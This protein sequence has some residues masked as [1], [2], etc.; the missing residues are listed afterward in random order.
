QSCVA[1]HGADGRGIK[2]A[3]SEVALAPSLVDSPRVHSEPGNLVMIL[4]HGL[5]GPLD[6]KT[7]QAGFMAPGAALGLTREREIARVLS[8][9]RYAWD[10]QSG[11]V[12]EAQVKG[13]KQATA[14][15]KIPWTQPE[16]EAQLP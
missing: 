11:P 1:C 13:I 16:L 8:Y 12:T 4:L 10:K 15:R 14:T 3:G 9:I 2:V 6:G 5:S 7:Y